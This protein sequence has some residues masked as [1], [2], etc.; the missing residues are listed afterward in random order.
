MDRS[1]YEQE[2]RM[3][4]K[5]LGI[6]YLFVNAGAW[7]ATPSRP[8]I[9]TLQTVASCQA[10]EGSGFDGT[11][12]TATVDLSHLSWAHVSTSLN[13]ARDSSGKFTWITAQG[14]QGSDIVFQTQG[15]ELA[16]PGGPSATNSP[17]T[18]RV[19]LRGEELTIPLNCNL[20]LLIP[21]AGVT[22]S[23]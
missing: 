4:I 5:L 18:L 20:Q 8:A 14:R 9:N 6:I 2:T 12:L 22:M 21:H 1:I 19:L 3:S 13:L 15:F 17:S 7:A 23:N 10:D 11:T 16:I